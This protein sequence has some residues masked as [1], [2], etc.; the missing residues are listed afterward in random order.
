VK[1]D[2]A[3]TLEV[4]TASKPIVFENSNSVT[5]R[6]CWHRAI[7]KRYFNYED[8]KNSV[9]TIAENIKFYEKTHHLI[10]VHN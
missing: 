5:C 4:A 8:Q 6:R 10:A 3:S 2:K 7:S 1:N 9:L